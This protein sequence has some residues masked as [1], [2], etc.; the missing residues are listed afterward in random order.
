MGIKVSVGESANGGET[1]C[2]FPGKPG[3]QIPSQR[4]GF[5]E[6]GVPAGAL[7]VNWADRFLGSG[8]S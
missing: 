8:F 1:S 6:G 7:E 4:A 2:L 5:G 3:Q